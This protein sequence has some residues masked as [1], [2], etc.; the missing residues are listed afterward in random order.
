MLAKVIEV[1]LLVEIKLSA[2]LSEA[3]FRQVE[4]KT[5][6][7][8]FEPFQLKGPRII[9]RRLHLRASPPHTC[10][11]SNFAGGGTPRLSVRMGNSHHK[12]LISAD[13]SLLQN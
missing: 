5:A 3:G 6:R 8:G 4:A 9:R 13:P 11:P 10:A 1:H 2:H 7:T 12:Q